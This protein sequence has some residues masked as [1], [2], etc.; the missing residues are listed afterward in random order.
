M[1]SNVDNSRSEFQLIE[2]IEWMIF[3]KKIAAVCSAVLEYGIILVTVTHSHLRPVFQT[4]CWCNSNARWCLYSSCIILNI[5]NSSLRTKKSKKK[6]RRKY[7]LKYPKSKEK[8]YFSLTFLL[9]FQKSTL[10]IYFLLTFW[11]L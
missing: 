6:V 8:V 4:C 5:Y 11:V 3:K 2:I 10:K 1:K 9:L 7:T